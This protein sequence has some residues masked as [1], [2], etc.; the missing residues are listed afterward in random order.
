ML[1]FTEPVPYI[2][3]ARRVLFNPSWASSPLPTA[4]GLFADTISEPQVAPISPSTFLR[5]G[6]RFHG[7]Q[8]SERQVYDVQVELKYVDLRE[9][10]L[11]GYLKI[12]GA[13]WLRASSSPNV[14]APGTVH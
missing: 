12:Q 6:A 3:M 13:S 8:Q 7:T 11:C 1:I 9:S 14:M 2:R 5:P 4:S 10:Y